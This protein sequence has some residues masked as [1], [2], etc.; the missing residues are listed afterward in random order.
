MRAGWLVHC[1]LVLAGAVILPGSLSAQ[2]EVIKMVLAEPELDPGQEQIV[3]VSLHNPS[4]RT[5]QAGLRVEV[6]QG[7]KRS[8]GIAKKR[9]A[10]VPAGAE[11]RIFFRLKAPRTP[12]DYD[13]RLQV[14]TGDFK[15]ALLPGNPLFYSAFKVTGVVPPRRASPPPPRRG[16]KR[17]AA[18]E[19]PSRAARLRT[20]PAGLQFEK[21]DLLWE[22]MRVAPTNLLV[23]EKFSVRAD[24]RNVGGDLARDLEVSLVHFNTRVPTRKLPVA[25]TTVDVLAPGEKIEMEFEYAFP[26]DTLLGDYHLV[27]TAD[28]AGRVQEFSE[29]NNERVTDIPLRVSVIRQIF[30]ERDFAFDEAGLFLFRWDSRKFDEFKVQVGTEATFENEENFFDIPQGEKWSTDHEVVPLAGE[31]PGMAAGLLLNAN[32]NVVFWRVVGRIAGTDSIGFSQ[33]LPFKIR[34]EAGTASARA[35]QALP[36]APAPPTPPGTVAGTPPATGGQASSGASTSL[37]ALGAG[38]PRPTFGGSRGTVGN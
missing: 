36:A 29:E 8:V 16:A 11:R 37:P 23:G 34:I 10:E 2:L 1:L 24:L 5:V 30:P 4:A 6:L 21:A 22:S 31:L 3:Q 20:P 32:T 38:S 28:S 9:T 15:R 18:P 19:A 33:A 14:F 35:A 12:G 25:K 7:R 26:E 27:L 13:V 17:A